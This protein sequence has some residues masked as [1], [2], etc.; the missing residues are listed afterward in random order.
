MLPSFGKK[1]LIYG[2]LVILILVVVGVGIVYFTYDPISSAISFSQTNPLGAIDILQKYIEKKP[3]NPR[4]HFILAK[5]H[6]KNN[7]FDEAL[8]ELIKP[9]R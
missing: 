6:L 8:V 2:L 3:Q 9:L 7:Q 4:A 5:L 1:Y